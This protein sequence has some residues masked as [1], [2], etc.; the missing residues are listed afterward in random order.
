MRALWIKA[1]QI[2]AGDQ[3]LRAQLMNE[4][5]SGYRGLQHEFIERRPTKGCA[6]TWNGGELSPRIR[7]ALQIELSE[8]PQADLPE[9][10]EMNRRCQRT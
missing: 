7:G 2:D 8:S 9:G 10:A 3:A 4:L 6:T 5:G 1:P